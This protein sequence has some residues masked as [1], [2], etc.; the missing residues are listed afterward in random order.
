MPNLLLTGA[1]FSHNWGG[2]LA[3]EAFEY[4]LGA[5]QVDSYLRSALWQAKNNGGGFEDALGALQVAYEND[6][7]E[8]NRK[9]LEGLTAALIGMF[10]AMNKA[11]AASTLEFSR[12]GRDEFKKFLAL[13]DAIFTLNQDTLLEWHYLGNVRWSENWAGSYL[14]HMTS[15]DVEAA[16]P[17]RPLAFPLTPA[18]DASC[19]DLQQPYYK[20][21]GSSNWF[22][23]PHGP[24]MLIM[25]AN[26]ARNIAGFDILVRYMEEFRRRLLL[27]E[28]RLM[29][30][31]YS[32]GDKHI[33][34]AIHEGVNH[35]T[36]KLFIVD[37]Q[38]IDLLNRVGPQ[39]GAP[40]ARSLR[41][42]LFK[43]LYGASRRP[44]RSIFTG[45]KV[46]HEK[47]FGFFDRS[48]FRTRISN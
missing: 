25:G 26:K 18:N 31:G 2:W 28:T 34:D 40:D 39:E 42:R 38:G 24:R 6:S 29:I 44:L 46:E 16:H 13:F 30:I 48:A 3:S 12:D 35:G 41:D 15:I 8:E 43:G 11:F 7:S 47:L 10:D 21:H 33:N 36:L 19:N 23:E 32:F 1:G 9:R 17:L 27:P 5:P 22:A 37:P 45:D 4:L 14:P 20:L